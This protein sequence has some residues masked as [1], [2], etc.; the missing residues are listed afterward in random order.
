MET[1]ILLFKEYSG[2][3]MIITLFLLSLGYLWYVEKNKE[4]RRLLVAFPICILLV[5]FCPLIIILL[6]KLSEEDVFWRMLWSVPVLCII[7]Y[8]SIVFIRKLEGIKRYLSILGILVIIVISGD[9]LYNN[10]NYQKAENLENIPSEVIEICDQVIVE[11]REVM[12]C[13]P[14]EMLMYVTQYTDYIKMPYG[15]EVFLKPDGINMGNLLYDLVEKEE[16]DAKELSDS[17]RSASCHFV[18]LRKSTILKGNL[19]KEN[20]NKFYEAEEYVIYLD[21]SNDPRF[22]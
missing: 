8:A 3:G 6:E 12:A 22:W 9:Y 16:V 4:N 21:A 20:W 17:L 10:P 18:V 15:R 1:A 14:A 11:G 2:H 13:F 7:A 19:E 5:F